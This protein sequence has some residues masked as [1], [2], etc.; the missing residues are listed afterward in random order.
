MKTAISASVDPKSICPLIKRTCIQKKC[1]FAL[2]DDD[3]ARC[4]FRV[5]ALV[6]TC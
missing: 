2:V 4:A 1:C 5:L 3:G 6:Q